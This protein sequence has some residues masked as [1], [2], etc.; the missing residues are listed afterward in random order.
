MSDVDYTGAAALRDVLHHLKSEG[1]DFAIARAGEHVHGELMR[2]GVTP[3][4]IPANR[5]FPDVDAAVRALASGP[6]SEPS[7]DA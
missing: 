3:A 7:R 1:I 4:L 2:A 6:L 5:F